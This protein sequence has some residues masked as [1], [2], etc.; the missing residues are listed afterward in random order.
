MTKTRGA[1]TLFQKVW[2]ATR[3]CELEANRALIHVD[4]HLLHDLSSPQ[5]FSGLRSAGRI[6]RNAR[7]CVAV[8]DHV[9]E[10]APDR[11]DD[12]VPGGREM[13]TALRA[14]ARSSGI[15]LF[16]LGDSRQ[17]IVHVTAADQGVVLPGMTVVCGDSH[18][19]TLGALGA[20]AF[21][22]G[23]S[24]I[25]HVLATQT[26]VMRKPLSSRITIKGL[27]APGVSSKDLALG[28][29]ARIGTG[30]AAGGVLEYAGPA[31]EALSM[32]ERFTLCNMGIEASARAAIIAP[33]QTT[34][35]YL[36]RR[37]NR[38]RDFDA[39]V[40]AWEGLKTD[41]GSN[42]HQE[43][44][45][46]CGD[47]APQISWGTNPSQT[48]AVDATIPEIDMAAP[49]Q[50][51]E[52]AARALAYMDLRPGQHLL[53]LPIQYVFI[54]SCTNSRLSDLISAAQVVRGRRV[55]AH[56]RAL[57]VPGSTLIKQE[58]ERL[59]LDQIFRTAG[60]EWRESGCSMCVGMNS[61]R[62]P[63]GTRCV[64]TSNRNFEGRQGKGART[65][66]ASPSSAAAAA[67][68]GCIVDVR[69]LASS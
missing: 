56:V 17:G 25:E 55:A 19:C 57:V 35:E 10:T 51:R 47:L 48:I 63:A 66:L 26:L 8:P 53:G 46:D 24:E 29:I 59:G 54:G 38:P 40:T 14:N 28:M 2:D 1:T 36:A 20:W 68:A 32:E 9:V 50:K 13:I 23:T 34:F 4:R 7:L 3:I 67:I 11:G 31:V 62:V 42:F 52:S 65:H 61:D 58:A 16:D 30:A 21:G 5:A 27:R 44:F 37:P 39:A 18:T 60:F 6:V 49:P 41:V 22:I 69:D 12:T 43:F 15:P 64:S 45:L 33:D